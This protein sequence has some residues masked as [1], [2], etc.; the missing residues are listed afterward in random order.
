MVICPPRR[1]VMQ[2]TPSE[3]VIF[4]GGVGCREHMLHDM[5]KALAAADLCVASRLLSHRK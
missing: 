3:R 2:L 5:H 4:A 1:Q